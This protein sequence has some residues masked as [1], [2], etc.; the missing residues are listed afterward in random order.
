VSA[1]RQGPAFPVEEFVQAL[2]AQLD[3][4]QDTLALKART[5]RPLT[6]ALKDMAVELKVFWEVQNGRLL[7]RHMVPG[8]E[9]ASTVRFTFTTITRAMVEE[10][11]FAV[12]MDDDG[13]RLEEVAP[14]DPLAD[15]DRRKLELAGVRTVGQLKRM[16][17][18]A[19]P[20]QVG[21]LLDIP[22][23]RLER[24]LR[25]SAQPMVSRTEAVGGARG[26]K[27]LRI[28][29]ANLSAADPPEVRLNGERVEVMEARPNELLVRPMS[30]HREGE[31]EIRVG[32]ARA[33]GF[34][35]LVDDENAPREGGEPLRPATGR[36]G[37][38][39]A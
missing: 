14:G 34:Y 24:L 23:N 7:M 8:E 38:A 37:E 27:L 33:Q 12:G 10:N 21:T 9:G 18:G 28:R 2:S 22:V 20:K 11:T 15:E 4:A 26:R 25:Q 35:D 16:S 17:Q 5:G 13:R 30:H 32:E 19:D 39:L 31:L 29:G 36:D 3:R 6:F 1:P